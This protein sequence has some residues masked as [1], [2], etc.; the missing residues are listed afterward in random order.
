M[1]M[2]CA[3]ATFDAVRTGGTNLLVLPTSDSA[4]PNRVEFSDCRAYRQLFLTE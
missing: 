2:N 1:F 4:R 3:A